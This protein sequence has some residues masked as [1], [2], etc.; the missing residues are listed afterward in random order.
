MYPPRITRHAAIRRWALRL[1]S[2]AALWVCL[3]A[4]ARATWA[5]GGPSVFPT[6]L[7]LHQVK[8]GTWAEYGLSVGGNQM[9][10]RLAVVA[11]DEKTTTLEMT[12]E[13]GPMAAMGRMI[14]QL[15]LPRDPKL[16]GRPSAVVVQVGANA[17]MQMPTNHPMAPKESFK[18][19]DPKTLSTKAETVKVPGGTF[20]ALKHV[21][22]QGDQEATT[23]LSEKAAPLGLVKMESKTQMGPATVELL[24]QGHDAKSSLS[25][26]PLPFDQNQFMQQLMSGM[27]GKK[28]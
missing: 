20:K 7:D 16:E 25:G 21:Q 27:S 12:V 19:L 9:K 10:Q 2:L 3:A 17:P 28:K 18:P 5:Q 15:A 1:T 4:G 22:T 11:R 14:L 24:K 13:G 6:L 8:P 26:K 23:W